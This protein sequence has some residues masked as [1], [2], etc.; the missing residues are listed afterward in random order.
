MSHPLCRKDRV[1][2]TPS[3]VDAEF[4]ASGATPRR[5][6]PI[7]RPKSRNGGQS[8][9]ILGSRRSEQRLPLRVQ[10]LSWRTDRLHQNLWR[11]EMRRREFIAGL[12]SV[13]A[14]SVTVQAQQ[15]KMPAI[16]V[17]DL[18]SPQRTIDIMAFRRGLAEAGFVD[19]QN[20]KIEFRW[21]YFQ[22]E[23]LPMLAADLVSQQVAVIVT[24]GPLAATF[25]AK[26]AT[27]SIPIV[28]WTNID[29]V[30]YGLVASLNRP[31]SNRRG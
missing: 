19:G 20:V 18:R 11:A 30:A 31:G 13:T 24:A 12:G 3:I 14:W 5:L 27:S 16:G 22:S 29:P 9:R 21:A 10:G 8:L 7:R 28:M 17:L 1:Y 4:Y 6:P 23:R 25:A 2:V 15:P 26:A